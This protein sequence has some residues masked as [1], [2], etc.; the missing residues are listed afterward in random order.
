MK[1]SGAIFAALLFVLVISFLEVGT[2]GRLESLLHQ[3]QTAVELVAEETPVDTPQ[4][5]DCA[6]LETGFAAKLDQSRSCQ[7][8]A[9][10]TLARF[11]CP[12]ECVT[13]V[14]TSLLDELKREEGT[15]QQACN[16]CVS[17]CPQALTKWRAAC[18]RQRCI[19]L[20]RSHD[21]L[22]EETL[23]RINESS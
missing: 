19:V 1:S 7:V 16:R 10:C 23:R 22:E 5:P 21:E 6:Q 20:D 12:F 11:E 17:D 4:E 13:S 2:S 3:D 8:D 18:V 15:F 14:S 9:D